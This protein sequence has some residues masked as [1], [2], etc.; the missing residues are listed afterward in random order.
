MKIAFLGD[1]C[2]S[3]K[4]DILS[5]G[6]VYKNFSH[7]RSVLSEYDYV[8]ANLES[9]FTT[10]DKSMVCKAVHIKSDPVNVGLL[11]YLGVDAVSLANNHMFDYGKSGY[12]TTVAAL[13]EAGIN[14]FGTCGKSIELDKDGERIMLGGFC[15]LSAHP[16]KA[17]S[18]GVN[19]LRHSS[20][21]R[22]FQQARSREAFP[23][24]SVHW[25]EENT[26]F[27]S[28][29]HV[30]FARLMAM[31]QSYILHGHHPHVVQ[32]VECYKGSLIA[33]SLGNFCTDQHVSRSVKNLVVP[34]TPEN[35]KS[36]VMGVTVRG[37]RLIS[38][39]LVP[40]FESDGFISVGGSDQLDEIYS[41]S[42]HLSSNQSRY[43]KPRH[44]IAE[45]QA[46]D[47][48][49][50]RRYSVPWFTSRMNYHFLGAFFKGIINRL[51][52]KFYFFPIRKKLKKGRRF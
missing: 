50:P 7:I 26:H 21:K 34:S 44:A 22:F 2:L 42:Q 12:R 28:E 43:E 32:G 45:V 13:D 25:G 15:C 41:Y 33:Y 9:P 35:H 40:I 46:N 24:L 31:Q 48:I 17:N 1:V 11:S 27:P 5:G 37:G 30:Q 19:V 18:K 52:Y 20:V 14:Y 49:S 10:L 6:D 51:R 29:D 38:S 36:F 39:E 4:F 8:V 47:P 16:S 23:V 3:G